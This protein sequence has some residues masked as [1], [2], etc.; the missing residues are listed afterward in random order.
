MLVFVNRTLEGD[1]VPA[2]AVSEHREERTTRDRGGRTEVRETKE[3]YLKKGDYDELHARGIDYQM[4]ETLLTDWMSADNQVTIMSPAA[5]R[6]KLTD[7]QIKALQDGKGQILTEV[8]KT[9]DVDILIQVQARATRQ[10]QRGLELRIIA[11]AINVRGGESLARGA[12]DLLPPMDKV[13]TN[14]KTRFLARKLMDGMTS[15]WTAPG[16]AKAK[17][18]DKPTPK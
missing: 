12:V 10:T 5:A 11:E 13:E 3:T 1:L 6:K 7:E 18:G 8:A 17:D 16:P 2:A 4:L 15:A 14:V 9:L